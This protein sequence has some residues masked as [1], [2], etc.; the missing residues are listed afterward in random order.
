MRSW[1][2]IT[3]SGTIR[4]M[5][6]QST[7]RSIRRSPRELLWGRWESISLHG[8]RERTAVLFVRHRRW[9]GAGVPVR[10]FVGHCE[11]EFATL[12]ELV[13]G[14]P[15]L[16]VRLAVPGGAGDIDV[17]GRGVLGDD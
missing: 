8:N 15:G 9:W 12:H 10:G 13:V 7:R 3:R 5:L 16:V 2:G 4:I 11:F 6:L 14:E 17:G 1:I